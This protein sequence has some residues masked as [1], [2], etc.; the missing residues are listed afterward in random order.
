MSLVG[1]A[2]LICA[3]AQMHCWTI[4]GERQAKKIRE[5]YFRSV[6]SQDVGWYD[7]T[8][9]GDLTNRLTSDMN[10]IQEG[11]SDKVG[12]LIQFWTTFLS[13]FIIGYYLG[14]KLALVLTGCLPFLS[15]AAYILAMVLADGSVQSQKA[16]A[17]AADIAQQVLSSIRTVYAFGGEEKEKKRYAKQLDVAE[18]Q[19]LKNHLMNG[20]G[21]G[22]I[23]FFLFNT[24][25]LA[26]WY[27]HVLVVNNTMNTGEVLSVIFSII[28]GAFSLGSASPHISSV[29]N[30]L[31]AAK[32]VFEIIERVSPIDP[33][34]EKGEKPSS[35][36][37]RVTFE[38]IGFHYPTRSDVSIL[39]DFNLVVE[40]GTT[41]A[42]VNCF[43]SIILIQL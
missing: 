42:L 29:G 23:N 18:K 25:A 27:G 40:N 22:L 6:V 2:T 28:F 13:G 9:T 36:K 15:G 17:G 5:L 1:L 26:F 30:A 34:S 35:V 21:M 33:L 12:L 4:A 38:N 43:D 3:T 39:K 11:I 7:K 10:I 14:W 19:G 20:S 37:G 31:G 41:V 24:F 16:Y 8:A 32:K